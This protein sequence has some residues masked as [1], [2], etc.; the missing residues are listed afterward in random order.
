LLPQ[1]NSW[2]WQDFN[3]KKHILFRHPHSHPTA[4]MITIFNDETFELDK[5]QLD[6]GLQLQVFSPIV[7]WNDVFG[8]LASPMPPL[9]G[10]A[11]N[12]PYN[13]TLSPLQ[14]SIKPSSFQ[15]SNFK[16]SSIKTM[17]IE[18]MP[19]Y[20]LISRKYPLCGAIACPQLPQD[21]HQINHGAMPF[22]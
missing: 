17:P 20:S 15:L 12:F 1:G 19:I 10:V 13:S 2:R 16:P 18:K 11:T 14:T 9:P 8:Q 3:L 7:E 5:N 6:L 21:K 4:T 22:F